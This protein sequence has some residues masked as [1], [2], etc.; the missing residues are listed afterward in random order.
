MLQA[1]RARVVIAGASG[2]VGRA[3]APAL[4]ESFEVV[5]LS[6]SVR[7][8]GAGFA[9]YRSC[10][11]FSLKEAEEAL[12]GAE[13][14]V[15]LVHNMMPSARLTQG[16]FADLDVVCADNFARAAASAGVKQIVF[17]SGLAPEGADLSRHLRSRSEVEQALSGH[18]VPVTTLRAGLILGGQGSSFQIM[19]R[20]VERL[21]VMVCPRWT[22]TKT[23]AIAI[24]DVVQ[25]IRGVLGREEHFDCT[26]D[27]GAPDVVTY[28]Q[29][30]ELTASAVGKRRVFLTSRV[31][32]PGLSRL[33]VSLITGAPKALVAPLVQSLKH[34]MVSRDDGL[35]ARLGIRRT[36]T[37]DAIRQA[38]RESDG[39]VPHAFRGARSQGRTVRSVQRMN[40]PSRWDARQAAVEYILWL[41]LFLSGLLR[42]DISSNQ[43]FSFR[44]APFRKPLLELTK[45]PE[46]SSADRQL[47]YVTGGLLSRSGGK[48]RF[49]LRQ[50][51]GGSTLLTVVHDYEP[52]LPWLVYV[53][54]QAVFHGWLMSRFAA[55]LSHGVT[56]SR[57]ASNYVKAL[58][59]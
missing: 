34:E 23:Q 51:L 43:R 49:E 52:R 28:K 56:S 58:P 47:F 40:L 46:R 42:V 25:F 5:G 6:R 21:P 50:V 22:N 8:P 45:A 15:Y 17:L 33:W 1:P 12:Q 30:M 9:E 26:H 4:A 48:P 18:V 41:P 37:A 2:F 35:A 3:L 27:I 24:R 32:S 13:Y 38:V 36:S 7:M 57:R 59:S 14:A 44:L 10:D 16:N 53:S 29:L 20:L 11:L 31:M 19:A 54:T 55:H 39:T